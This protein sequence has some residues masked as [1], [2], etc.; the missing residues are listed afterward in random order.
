MSSTGA[1]CTSR[2]PLLGRAEQAAQPRVVGLTVAAA[3][4]R[5]R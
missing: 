4:S 5:A 2:L 3:P 1:S